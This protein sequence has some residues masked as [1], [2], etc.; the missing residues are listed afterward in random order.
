MMVVGAVR[1]TGVLTFVRVDRSGDDGEG[2]GLVRRISGFL[3]GRTWTI[4]VTVH[5]TEPRVPVHV[6]RMSTVVIP[7]FYPGGS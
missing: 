6:N 4:V 2:R 3:T 1:L 7:S 5:V